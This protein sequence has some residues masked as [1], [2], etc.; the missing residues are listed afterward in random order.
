[1]MRNGPFFFR[2]LGIAGSAVVMAMS[3]YFFATQPDKALAQ[4]LLVGGLAGTVINGLG[5]YFIV[6]NQRQGRWSSQKGK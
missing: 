3:A 4:Y 2:I 6:R 5:L 1:M